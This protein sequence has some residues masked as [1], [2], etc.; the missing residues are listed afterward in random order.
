MSCSRTEFDGLEELR[1][2]FEREELAL[3]RHEDRVRR[4]HCVDGQKIERRRAIDQDVSVICL[5]RR[6]RLERRKRAAQTEGAV[7]R[8]TDFK[9]KPRKIE[10]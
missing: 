1:Q 8:L 2:S 6:R 10:G 3:Q 4:R 7:A 9:F 5:I